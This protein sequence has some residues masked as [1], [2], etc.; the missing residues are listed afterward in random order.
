MGCTFGAVDKEVVG[1]V[2]FVFEPEQFVVD[3][4]EGLVIS[5]DLM[6]LPSDLLV[7][8]VYFPSVLLGEL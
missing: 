3:V 2:E 1:V 4:Q 6:L 5:V 7:A 8:Q